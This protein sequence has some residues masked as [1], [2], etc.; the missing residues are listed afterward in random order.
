MPL[1]WFVLSTEGSSNFSKTGPWL[2]F[3]LLFSTYPLVFRFQTI[4]LWCGQGPSKFLLPDLHWARPQSLEGHF[5]SWHCSSL[6]EVLIS[7]NLGFT[8]ESGFKSLTCVFCHVRRASKCH[9][10]VHHLV[11]KQMQ[12]WNVCCAYFM[13][14][15]TKQV[16]SCSCA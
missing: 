9:T 2:I 6:S 16:P 3:Q 7:L 11:Q 10:L 1:F 15:E 12:N 5:L 8:Q 4:N 13:K 14:K